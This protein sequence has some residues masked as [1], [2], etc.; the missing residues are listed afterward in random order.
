MH[1]NSWPKLKVEAHFQAALTAFLKLL[2]TFHRW[3]P[4]SSQISMLVE[5]YD[6]R[7]NIFTLVCWKLEKIVIGIV[8]ILMHYMVLVLNVGGF[9]CR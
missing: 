1:S 5:P 8:L 7:Y 2:K 9:D 4:I 3:R 6:N